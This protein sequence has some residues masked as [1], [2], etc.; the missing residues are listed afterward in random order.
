M[1][2]KEENVRNFPN[3]LREISMNDANKSVGK[4]F[5]SNIELPLVK[6]PRG[7]VN[8]G[9]RN[10][11]NNMLVNIVMGKN[12]DVGMFHDEG[13]GSDG[14]S[15]VS[16]VRRHGV[17]I[18]G[19]I[20][21]G[22]GGVSGEG[23][24]GVGLGGA[25]GEGIR[26]VSV[27]GVSEERNNLVKKDINFSQDV[28]RGSL[29]GG[30]PLNSDL[31]IDPHEPSNE[32]STTYSNGIPPRSCYPP[33]DILWKSMFPDRPPLARASTSKSSSTY[34]ASPLV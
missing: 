30:G 9:R 21:V 11:R 31:P 10:L 18:G 13:G 14:E 2:L 6:L 24:C 20:E 23:I 1:T 8:F 4:I 22:L 28:I 27:G 34:Q 29:L 26:G 15:G 16:G 33:L 5:S 32:S 3:D 25:S 7:E 12:M 19:L 17:G